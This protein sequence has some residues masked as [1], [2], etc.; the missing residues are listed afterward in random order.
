MCRLLALTLL[1]PTVGS[2]APS[3]VV[4]EKIVLRSVAA[5]PDS[6]HVRNLQHRATRF[7]GKNALE[8]S[9]SRD[10][11]A[12][13]RAGSGANSPTYLTLANGFMSGVIELDIAGVINGKGGTESRAF[14]GI[15][16]NIMH[17]VKNGMAVEDYE[18]VYLRMANGMLNDPVP[19]PPRNVRAIQYATY[20]DFDFSVSRERAPGVY[21]KAADVALGQWHKLRVELCGSKVIAKVD[22]K[23]A[24]SVDSIRSVTRKGAIGIW[25]GDGTNAYIANFRVWPVQCTDQNPR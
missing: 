5:A 14:A 18:M 3:I 13:Q 21:E 8:V 4:D 7:A 23:I 6:V 22:G 1:L 25:V 11:Q 9:L 24:L 12:R 19:P 15:A 16:F 2:C 10:E 17:E 20:P